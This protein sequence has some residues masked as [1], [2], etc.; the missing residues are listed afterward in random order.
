[1]SFAKRWHDG[2]WNR[3]IASTITDDLTLSKVRIATAILTLLFFDLHFAWITD[4]P[5]SLFA[6]HKL[7]LAILFKDMPGKLCFQIGEILL[8][9][10]VFCVAIG[11][12]S[13]I[14][15]LL[16]AFTY[17]CLCSFKYSFGKID[18]TIMLP[19]AFFC[20]ALTN[21]GCRW[22]IIPDREKSF[23]PRGETLLSITLAFGMFTAGLP[24]AIHWLDFDLTHNGFLSWFYR[25]Y[26]SMERQPFGAS[27]VF[28]MPAWL[29]EVFDY[30]AVAF[31]LS[32][33]F[34]LLL[35]RTY[36]RTWIVVACLFHT[37]NTILLGIPFFINIVAYLPFIL[38][39]RQAIAA[40]RKNPFVSL[41][42]VSFALAALT[43]HFAQTF[44]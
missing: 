15:C 18:H 38:L 12:K 11:L 31:E 27:L 13:R 3:L 29:T 2:V 9:F 17:I 20:L 26:F 40:P 24:K 30:C 10:S 44:K 23:V 28:Q 32:P 8:V 7:S 36:W 4:L 1:M 41:V 5:P 16:F 43:M 37:F 34:C 33:F 6:P 39:D 35:G 14:N 42:V 21:A 22:A 19:A 25:G